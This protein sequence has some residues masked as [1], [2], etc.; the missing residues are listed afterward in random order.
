MADE[1]S[2]TDSAAVADAATVDDGQAVTQTDATHGD[3][4]SEQA[5]T[6]PEDD[7]SSA[8]DSE[9][10]DD[11]EDVSTESQ[12]DEEKTRAQRRRERRQQRDQERINT[13]VAETLAR[14]RKV[15][16]DQTAK[17]EAERK[18]AEAQT[19]WHR[20][21]GDLVGTPEI[22][23][24]LQREIN[25]LIAQVTG[26][27]NVYE[28]TAEA[29]EKLEAA[30]VSLIEKRA[31][32]AELDTNQTTF[33]K[34]ERY[35]FSL[36]AGAYVSKAESLPSEFGKQLMAAEGVPQALDILE[37]GI[38]AREAAKAKPEK[39][40]AVEETR[41][42]WQGM[43][44]KEVS[45]HASTRTG[46]AGAGP[47][48]SGN[49]TASSSGGSLTPERY[50]AMSYDDRQKLRSTPEGRAQIDEMSRSRTGFGQRSA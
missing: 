13:A 47:T 12:T 7:A 49:G 25:D 28:A 35:Q 36:D 22:R 9:S 8:T 6:P 4:S 5:A 48:P 33:S 17:A 23:Q 14:E 31:R 44:E 46:L 10:D 15:A 20:E 11:E 34:I 18:Q 2:V 42:H 40:A 43:Y 24:G 27:G 29:V 21:F 1:A 41:K 50:A 32:L 19:N 38:V 16:A 45:A 30:R 26:T 39:D 37:R 3:A